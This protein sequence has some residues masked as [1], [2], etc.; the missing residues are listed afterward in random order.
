LI[1]R[2]GLDSRRGY[3]ARNHL[4][5]RTEC[6]DRIAGGVKLHGDSVLI[7]QFGKLAIDVG[8]I[9]FTGAGL[10]ATGY[11]GDVDQADHIDMLL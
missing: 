4:F 6:R 9:D 3:G 5:C 11:V 10:V 8:V 2:H 1:E 7:V